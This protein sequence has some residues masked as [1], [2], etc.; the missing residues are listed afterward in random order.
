M[1]LK[2]I[3]NHLNK[4]NQNQLNIKN[5]FIYEINNLIGI[6]CGNIIINNELYNKSKFGL[7]KLYFDIIEPQLK[8]L[9]KEKMNLKKIEK[10]I[11]KLTFRELLQVYYMVEKATNDEDQIRYNERFKKD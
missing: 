1:E 3:K 5:W 9:N 6:K 10:E 8:H 7:N 4:I 2:Q 11:K